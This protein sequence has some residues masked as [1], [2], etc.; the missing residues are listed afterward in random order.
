MRVANFWTFAEVLTYRVDR[1]APAGFVQM[2]VGLPV[3]TA[4]LGDWGV[5]AAGA[6]AE[7]LSQAMCVYRFSNYRH[8]RTKRAERPS[9]CPAV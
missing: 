7:K 8:G 4:P 3:G 5:G 1:V 6:E 9:L 2:K